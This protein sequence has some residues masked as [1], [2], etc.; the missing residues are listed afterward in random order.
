MIFFGIGPTR[1]IMACG[2]GNGNME[3]SLALQS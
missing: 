2:V 3:N 1:E